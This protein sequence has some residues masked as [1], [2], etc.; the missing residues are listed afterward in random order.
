MHNVKLLIILS[1]LFISISYSA[2]DTLILQNGL[3]NYNGTTDTYVGQGWYQSA[4]AVHG[5]EKR[6]KFGGD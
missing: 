4:N 2:P 5:T 6:I 3:N 1:L